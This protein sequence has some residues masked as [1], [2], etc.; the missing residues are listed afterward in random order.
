MKG[1]IGIFALALIG[2]IL[3]TANTFAEG[4]TNEATFKTTI[5]NASGKDKVETVVNMLKG[6]KEAEMNIEKKELKVKYDPN[7]INSDMIEYAVKSLGFDATVLEDKE[8]K[9][10]AKKMSDSNRN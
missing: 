10:D 7:Q 4:K 3:I 8:I 2:L 6:V 9:D 5:N 1:F